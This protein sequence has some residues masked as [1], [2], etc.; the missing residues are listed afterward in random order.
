MSEPSPRPLKASAINMTVY[1]LPDDHRRL[2]ILAAKQDTT[3]QALVLDGL[4]EVMKK[5]GEPL[6]TR[7]APRRRTRAA[8]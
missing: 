1:L 2:R 7:W 8:A 3:I 4:D 6:V 5:N